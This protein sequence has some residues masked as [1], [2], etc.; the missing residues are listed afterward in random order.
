VVLQPT[1]QLQEDLCN[2]LAPVKVWCDWLLGNNDTWYPLVSAEPFAQLAQLATRLEG[3]NTQVKDILEEC[4]N[5][6]A[7]LAQPQ[8]R[9]VEFALPKLAEDALLCEYTPW[10]RSLIR[11]SCRQ[12]C[13]RATAAKRVSQIL[14][15]VKCLEGLDQ[16][17]LKWSLPDNSHVC[18]VTDNT[19]NR[20]HFSRDIAVSNLTA[21]G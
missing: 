5:E 10:F 18:L 2:L 9:R 15:A 6:K 12:C 8:A 7:F 13:P 14:L 19:T 16:P 20:G 17:V 1:N 3:V 11:E 4:H 21:M